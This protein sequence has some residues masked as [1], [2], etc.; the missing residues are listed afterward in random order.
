MLDT[1]LATLHEELKATAKHAE[2]EFYKSPSDTSLM[3]F[4]DALLKYREVLKTMRENVV[5]TVPNPTPEPTTASIPEEPEPPHVEK[6]APSNSEDTLTGRAPGNIDIPN[7]SKDERAKNIENSYKVK[8]DG[9]YLTVPWV[10]LGT[11]NRYLSFFNNEA[12]KGK[13]FTQATALKETILNAIEIADFRSADDAARALG[14]ELDTFTKQKE[15]TKEPEPLTPPPSTEPKPT[16]KD[17]KVVAPTTPDAEPYEDLEAYRNRGFWNTQVSTISLDSEK[18]WRIKKGS[19]Y[20]KMNDQELTAWLSIKNT[21]TE[22]SSFVNSP[23]QAHDFSFLVKQKNELLDALEATDFS[24]AIELAKNLAKE[25]DPMLDKE[26][27]PE[28]EKTAARIQHET[29]QFNLSMLA[30]TDNLILSNDTSRF[31][32]IKDPQST[33]HREYR[34]I[35]KSTG[36]WVPLTKKD[37]AIVELAQRALTHFKNQTSTSQESVQKK[38]EILAHINNYDFDGAKVAAEEYLAAFSGIKK[39]SPLRPTVSGSEPSPV[40]KRAMIHKIVTEE[41]ERLDSIEKILSKSLPFLTSDL[42]KTAFT[43]L[44]QKQKVLVESLRANPTLEL[45]DA[46]K[47]ANDFLATELL[48]KKSFIEAQFGNISNSTPSLL[49]NDTTII[50][51]ARLRG[52]AIA[53]ETLGERAARLKSEEGSADITQT[54]AIENKAE[55]LE[56]HKRMFNDDPTAYK[57]IY[58]HE[59]KVRDVI[60]EDIST[61]TLADI[62]VPHKNEEERRRNFLKNL[63]GLSPQEHLKELTLEEHAIMKRKQDLIASN[64]HGVTIGNYDEKMSAIDAELLLIKENKKKYTGAILRKFT[65][66][67]VPQKP[68]LRQVYRPSQDDSRGDTTQGLGRNYEFNENNEAVKIDRENLAQEQIE[69]TFA[70]EVNPNDSQGVRPLQEKVNLTDSPYPNHTKGMSPLFD[71]E[72]GEESQHAFSNT[73]IETVRKQI[74]EEQAAKEIEESREHAN[75]KLVRGSKLFE[76]LVKKI[77]PTT[78]KQWFMLGLATL[79]LATGAGL[80]F[81]KE[82]GGKGP[83]D[84]RLLDEYKKQSG[85]EKYIADKVSKDFLKDFSGENKLNYKELLVKYG[86]SFNINPNNPSVGDKLSNLLCK[87]VYFVVGANAG[88]SEKQQVESSVLID[89]LKEIMIA[90]KASLGT[91]YSEEAIQ[92][93]AIFGDMTI[94]QYYDAV[95]K[96]VEKAEADKARLQG[97]KR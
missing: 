42:E 41:L 73:D 72:N 59:N 3:K 85:W 39:T 97:I 2:A 27:V 63:V 28:A 16:P 74:E 7:I 82:A 67:E 33:T 91:L 61:H 83:E 77:K 25:F 21:L 40:A 93:G 96:E 26:K 15:V 22:Y 9:R 31:A 84:R 30:N 43:K 13:D 1:E 36:E 18:S 92:S 24:R 57:E 95:S 19:A 58:A 86:P 89:N 94:Q 87:D 8:I 20:V 65:K 78:T 88:I 79:G 12:N 34:I 5:I 47:R 60:T 37:L 70:N 76:S 44:L 35:N 80:A 46:F 64:L 48:K 90:A 66:N 14:A 6:S 56:L 55:L 51:N 50:R 81:G 68:T 53:K 75:E 29:R 62:T 4:D 11:L 71:E 54:K 23:D 10:L 17:I 69:D 52:T 32:F 38:N 45:V 49:N